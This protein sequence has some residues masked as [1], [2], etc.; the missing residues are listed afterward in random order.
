VAVAISC[1]LSLALDGPKG[2]MWRG[3]V[4]GACGGGM[5]RGHVEGACGG[6]M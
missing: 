6:G 5:W 4:E 1:T 3:H 2:G